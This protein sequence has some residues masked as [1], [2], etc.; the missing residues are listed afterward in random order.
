MH[1]GSRW[2][3][4]GFGTFITMDIIYFLDVNNDAYFGYLVMYHI[5]LVSPSSELGV[6][7]SSWL[8]QI[9]GPPTPGHPQ[10]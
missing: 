4:M 3:V 5:N 1:A 2:E 10:L 6:N 7:A 8:A 9:S